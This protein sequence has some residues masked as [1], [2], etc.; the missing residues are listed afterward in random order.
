MAPPLPFSKLLF[1]PRSAPFL[2]APQIP[3]ILRSGVYRS[4]SGG[5]RRMCASESTS[6][7]RATRPAP[8]VNGDVVVR[9]GAGA[10]AGGKFRFADVSLGGFLGVW[11]LLALLACWLVG[12]FM[13]VLGGGGGYGFFSCCL[14]IQTKESHSPSRS[15]TPF[16]QCPFSPCVSLYSPPPP[17]PLPF[18]K[19]PPARIITLKTH[20]T[21]SVSISRT[22][23]TAGSTTGNKSTRTILRMCCSALLRLGVRR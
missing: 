15:T 1:R 5:V 6:T 20:P 10:G 8:A 17:P 14:F 23:S 21:R 22:Q 4:G 13:G 2:P 18:P 3:R 9:A 7:A 12:L 19:P 16:P 11:G